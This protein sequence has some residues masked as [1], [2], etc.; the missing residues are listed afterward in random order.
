[1]VQTI[2]SLLF[3]DYDSIYRSLNSRVPTSGDQLGSRA[4]AWLEALESGELITPRADGLR[5]RLQ[6]KRCYAD[7]RLLGKNRGWLTANGVQI[8]DCASLNGS[9]RSPSDVHMVLD[10]V[11]ALDRVADFDEFILLTAE[12]DLTPLLFRLRAH[13]RRIVTFVG[14]TTAPSYRAFADATVTETLLLGLLARP[15]EAA[16]ARPDP[17]AARIGEGA[18]AR[19]Q[20]RAQERS[21]ERSQER[22][23]GRSNG[24]E[25][26]P[27]ARS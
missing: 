4:G 10:A 25:A 11:D 13:N 7:P 19:A 16:T 6:V 15:A 14:D 24:A 26:P 18:L 8:V 2:K 23:G 27:P 5:R 17:L 9:L 1:M 20:A 12:I 21:Q 22:A 3:F